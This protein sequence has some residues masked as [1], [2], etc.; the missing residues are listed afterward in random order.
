MDNS[1]LQLID[2]DCVKNIEASNSF[3]GVW[4]RTFV[5]VLT[6]ILNVMF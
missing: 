2:L 4:G 5:T 3:E 6:L 1:N